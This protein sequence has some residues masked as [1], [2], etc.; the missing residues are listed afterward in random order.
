MNSGKLTD[1]AERIDRA[2]RLLKDRLRG[3]EVPGLDALAD[4]AALSPF[5]FH[6]VFRLMTGETVNDAVRRIRLAKGGAALETGSVT[7]A[8]GEAAYATSQ[9]FARAMRSAT[10]MSA[11]EALKS[12]D[13]AALFAPPADAQ[14]L[15]IT[16]VSINP[17]EVVAIRNVG[18]YAELNRVYGRLYDIAGGPEAVEAIWGVPHSD[19]RVEAPEAC[20]FD[21]ALKVRALPDDLAEAHAA[22]LGGGRYLTLRHRG[23]YD[24][25]PW[26]I[27]ALVLAATTDDRVDLADAPALVR[28]LDDPEEVAEPDLRTDVFLPVT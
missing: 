19:P 25:V 21:A 9:A 20:V 14:P 3:D 12:P 2:V 17:F 5:H 4:A 8:A 15:A 7:E 13:I 28:Y 26:A 27:D 1:Y 22:T 11:R 18:D 6:R 16:L 23:D 10:G 24:A